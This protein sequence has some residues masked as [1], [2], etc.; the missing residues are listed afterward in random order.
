MFNRLTETPNISTSTYA[1]TAYAC[2]GGGGGG[3]GGFGQAL[4]ISGQALG[5]GALMPRDPDAYVRAFAQAQS[6]TQPAPEPEDTVTRRLVQ[7]FIA[8]SDEN[9]PLV[10]SLLYSGE[11]KLTDLTD[12]ELYFEID[13]KTI[14]DTHNAKRA[15]IV[16]KQVRER[17]E[18]LE[19]A[20]IRD[21]KMVVV[22]I[23]TF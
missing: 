8:D 7:V 17:T 10:D 18:Y 12:Q 2:A 5:I 3:G 16:N 9:V 4:G 1:G 11:Q 22:N 20:R 23:A 14:L 19:P 21:L 15:K 6:N 13:I